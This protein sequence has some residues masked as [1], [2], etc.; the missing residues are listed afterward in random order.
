MG[1]EAS[2]QPVP[3][4]D[5]PC[6][7]ADIQGSTCHGITIQLLKPYLSYAFKASSWGNFPHD[8]CTWRHEWCREE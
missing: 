4:L 2:S 3:D 1:L 6:T 7:C 5:M 8:K